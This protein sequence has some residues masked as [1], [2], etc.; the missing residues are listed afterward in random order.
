MRIRGEFPGV[1]AYFGLCF[2]STPV[3]KCASTHGQYRC[4]ATGNG[5]M[6]HTGSVRY[7]TAGTVLVPVPVPEF[8]PDSHKGTRSRRSHR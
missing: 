7:S 8:S 1:D 6:A 5:V 4:D 3:G 2:Q